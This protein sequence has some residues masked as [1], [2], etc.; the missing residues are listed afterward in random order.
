M[1]RK[2]TKF[3]Y[4]HILRH[5]RKVGKDFTK[6]ERSKLKKLTFEDVFISEEGFIILGNSDGTMDWFANN[7]PGRCVRVSDVLKD[8]SLQ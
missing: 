2:L 4:K 5:Q 3:E 6:K 7:L 1:M 8:R